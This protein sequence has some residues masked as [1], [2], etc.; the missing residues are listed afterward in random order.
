[1]RKIKF[2]IAVN[3]NNA[4]DYAK[5]KELESKEWVY[6]ND[7][8]KIRGIDAKNVEFV[9]LDGWYLNTFYNNDFDLIVRE[10]AIL[11]A[12]KTYE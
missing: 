5:E 2:V 1:M 12:K 3:H 8:N 6:F 10:F 4:R 7:L 11:G 9:F